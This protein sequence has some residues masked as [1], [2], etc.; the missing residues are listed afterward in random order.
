[1]A[2]PPCGR[3]IPTRL[4][5][6]ERTA[7]IRNHTRISLDVSVPT[8]PSA[9]SPKVAAMGMGSRPVTARCPGRLIHHQGIRQYGDHSCARKFLTFGRYL[10]NRG[11]ETWPWA[12]VIVVAAHISLCGGVESRE[13]SISATPM[14]RV[15]SIQAS[16]APGSGRLSPTNPTIRWNKVRGEERWTHSGG[17]SLVLY[18]CKN[19]LQEH[20]DDPW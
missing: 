16:N 13:I 20:K 19:S 18:T 10:P 5:T 17:P 14:W 4:R 2:P 7:L 3:N 15:G 1:M 11:A 8:P 9:A 6:P 12:C